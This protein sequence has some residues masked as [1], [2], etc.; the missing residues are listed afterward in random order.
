MGI[1]YKKECNSFDNF[2]RYNNYERKDIV[3]NER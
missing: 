2:I 1:N 3:G